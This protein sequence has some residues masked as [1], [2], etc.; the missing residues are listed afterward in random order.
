MARHKY[1][2]ADRKPTVG[3]IISTLMATGAAVLFV[4]AVKPSFDAGGNGGMTVGSYALSALALSVF[5]L[6]V[7]LLSYKETD[8]IYRFSFLGTLASGIMTVILVM[9]LLAGL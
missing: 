9:L 4:Y 2:F 8:R 1:K 5:G 3:G 6:I 7:G